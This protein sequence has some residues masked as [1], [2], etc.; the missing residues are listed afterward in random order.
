MDLNEKLLSSFIAF[1]DKVNVND[2]VHEIRTA[3]L[4]RFE[5][6]GFPTKKLEAWKYT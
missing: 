5:Q 3:A 1:E 2:E 6:Q 4:K